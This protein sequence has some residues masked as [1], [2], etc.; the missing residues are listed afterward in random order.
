MLARTPKK[1]LKTHFSKVTRKKIYQKISK[2]EPKLSSQI[3]KMLK[4]KWLKITKSKE[5]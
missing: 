4:K 3:C 1:E 2:G 5:N